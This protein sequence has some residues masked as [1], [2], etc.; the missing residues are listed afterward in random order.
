MQGKSLKLNVYGRV[1]RFNVRASLRG[2]FFFFCLLVLQVFHVKKRKSSTEAQ[3][4]DMLSGDVVK[5]NLVSS[6]RTIMCWSLPAGHFVSDGVASLCQSLI[7]ENQSDTT[8]RRRHHYFAGL[9]S[10]YSCLYVRNCRVEQRPPSGDI[11]A[12]SVRIADPGNVILTSQDKTSCSRYGNQI[13]S[14]RVNKRPKYHF[15]KRLQG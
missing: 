2:F 3:S 8:E 12:F 5:W 4:K 10:D 13:P 14:G 1:P 15:L 9:A 11:L 6:H 7:K